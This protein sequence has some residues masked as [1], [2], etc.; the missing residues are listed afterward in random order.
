LTFFRQG[1]Y[2]QRSKSA[3]QQVFEVTKNKKFGTL[4]KNGQGGGGENP[5]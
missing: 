1:S 4:E 5:I 2:N 3:S